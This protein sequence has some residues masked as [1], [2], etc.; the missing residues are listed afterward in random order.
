MRTEATQEFHTPTRIVS[1]TSG[2]D[3]S[4]SLPSLGSILTC[5]SSPINS[6]GMTKLC[7]LSNITGRK[8]LRRG[9]HINSSGIRWTKLFET[10]TISTGVST[11]RRFFFSLLFGDEI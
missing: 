6:I 7:Y 2:L 5:G 10:R 9:N 1:S 11:S 3:L 4:L 8:H